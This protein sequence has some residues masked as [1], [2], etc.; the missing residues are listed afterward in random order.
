MHLWLFS[1]YFDISISC[2]YKIFTWIYILTKQTLLGTVQ[3]FFLFQCCLFITLMLL[4]LCGC[5][6]CGLQQH[7]PFAYKPLICFW[8]MLM[9]YEWERFHNTMYCSYLG[10]LSA[11]SLLQQF[12][13]YEKKI[14]L[15]IDLLSIALFRNL[16]LRDSRV[17]LC[18]SET[19]I[20]V[21]RDKK[22]HASWPADISY[23][24][25][26]ILCQIGSC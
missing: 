1:I 5:L 19:H 10:V 3:Y 8:L 24:Q 4:E 21:F 26:M 11:F 12:Y 25:R 17:C 9:A 14:L 6:V 13:F 15:S 23:W 20:H 18:I 7:L 2:F 16:P 22:Q